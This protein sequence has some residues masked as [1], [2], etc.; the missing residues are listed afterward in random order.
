MIIQHFKLGALLAIV[1]LTMIFTTLAMSPAFADKSQDDPVKKIWVKRTEG[2]CKAILPTWFATEAGIEDQNVRAL[3]TD[4]YMGHAR[5]AV[6]GVKPTLD[7]KD[8]ALSEVPAVILHN[9]T[10]INLDI[11]RPLAGRVLQVRK[12]EQ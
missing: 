8:I 9:K 5:L 6:F 12:L 11:Y 3:V 2:F 10:G 4:C 7:L 1:A